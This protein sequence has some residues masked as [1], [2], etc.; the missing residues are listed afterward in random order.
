ML[1]AVLVASVL[2]AVGISIFNL[3]VKELILSAAGRESQFAFYAADTGA[4]CALYWDFKGVDVFATSTGDRTP[5]P[6]TPDCVD[7]TGQAAQTFDVTNYVT[8]T[9]YP[10]A[11]TPTSAVTQF[12][13]NLPSLSPQYCAIVTVIKDS[14]SGILKTVIDSRG[15]NLPCSDT[16]N[17]NR[18][19]RALKVTY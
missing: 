3:T 1:F 11:R 5:S 7:T 2:L 12:T 6:A 13:L 17:P 4:E 19:E 9:D 14:S 15:Y 18:V 10:V 16:T 8:Y